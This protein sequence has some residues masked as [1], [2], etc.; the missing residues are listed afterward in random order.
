MSGCRRPDSS[1]FI[2]PVLSSEA[3]EIRKIMMMYIRTDTVI[4]SVM[5]I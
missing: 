2:V 3:V 1:E 5:K 4:F